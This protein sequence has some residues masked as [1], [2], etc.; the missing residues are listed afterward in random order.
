MVHRL[1]EQKGAVHEKMQM[2]TQA[3]AQ[4]GIRT[5]ELEELIAQVENGEMLH[6]PRHI[7]QD[8]FQKIHGQEHEAKRRKVLLYQIKVGVMMA[9]AVAV[10]IFMPS[11]WEMGGLEPI[12]LSCQ[13]SMDREAELLWQE[14][15][16]KRQK[17]EE[18]QEYLGRWERKEER[19]RFL[20][21]IG[22]SLTI[23]KA[24]DGGWVDEEKE[25]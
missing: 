14:A 24:G 16:I 2:E 25:K 20:R 13:E 12:N 4:T 22:N 9:A 17:E 15:E 6:C 7:K 1:R 3:K 21:E 11:D 18:W 8:V 5:D 10:L 23:R 19:D